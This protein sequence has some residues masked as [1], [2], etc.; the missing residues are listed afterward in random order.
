MPDCRTGRTV[1]VNSTRTSRTRDSRG[2][3]DSRD[4]RSWARSHDL[5]RGH[6]GQTDIDAAGNIPRGIGSP[7]VK[8]A[9]RLAPEAW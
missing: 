1:A 9:R 4:H 8:V 5:V 6:S 3:V 7:Q 2:S